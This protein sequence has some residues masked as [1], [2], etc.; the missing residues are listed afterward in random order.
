MELSLNTCRNILN[1]TCVQ[2]SSYIL[3]STHCTHI[4]THGIIHTHIYTRTGTH[5][6]VSVRAHT[7]TH[8]HTHTH[9][10]ACTHTRA[11][12][13]THIHTHMHAHAHYYYY[14]YYTYVIPLSPLVFLFSPN[15][16]T[17]LLQTHAPVLNTCTPQHTLYHTHAILAYKSL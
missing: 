10:H 17:V 16:Q 12:A 2:K 14:Y 6:H 5:T 3:F 11:R 4:Q 9:A 13:C 1:Y 8:T 15:N 7:H